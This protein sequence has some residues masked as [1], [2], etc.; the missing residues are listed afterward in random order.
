MMSEVVSAIIR[1]C[2]SWRRESTAVTDGLLQLGHH[3][4]VVVVHV[5]LEEVVEGGRRLVELEEVGDR[6]VDERRA[7]L[8]IDGHDADRCGVDRGAQAPL[9][10]MGV[11]LG[12]HR[13]AHH[14]ADESEQHGAD[15]GRQHAHRHRPRA[16]ERVVDDLDARDHHERDDR[17]GTPQAERDGV[18]DRDDREPG[19]DRDDVR[20]AEVRCRGEEQQDRGHGAHDRPERAARHDQRH[21]AGHGREACGGRE[22]RRTVVGHEVGDDVQRQAEQHQR[23]AA[24]H[25]A[26]G[27][28]RAVARGVDGVWR[29]APGHAP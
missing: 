21:G 23:L 6:T 11:A 7:A 8:E 16:V 15:H 19:H 25:D 3:V 17:P 28:R 13:L 14:V 10:L 9:A 5:V 1:N 26:P 4:G 2:S 20:A 27:D 12:Q 18:G 24:R 29:A 22:C